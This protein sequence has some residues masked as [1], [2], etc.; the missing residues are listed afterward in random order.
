MSW[1]N[2]CCC[3][4]ILQW[5][6][7]FQYFTQKYVLCTNLTALILQETGLYLYGPSVAHKDAAAINHRNGDITEGR[8]SCM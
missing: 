3:N 1:T 4:N 7:A 2:I 5:S 8:E 6:A